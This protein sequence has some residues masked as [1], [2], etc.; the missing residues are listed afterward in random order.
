MALFRYRAVDDGGEQKLGTKAA[1]DQTHL[2]QKLKFEGYWL[3][4]AK[5]EKFK[6]KSLSKSKTSRREVI[7]LFIALSTMLNAGVPL[8][9]TLESMAEQAKNPTIKHAL[10]AITVSVNS[11]MTLSD[12]MAMHDDL[13]PKQVTTIVLAGETS[14]R[15]PET[16]AELRRYYEW[17]DQL[18]G[19]VKQA[20]TYPL[21][22]LAVVRVF[23]LVLFSFVVPQFTELLS[24]LDVDP[25]LVTVLVLSISDL[26]VATWWSMLATPF[27]IWFGLKLAIKKSPKFAQKFDKMK[28]DIPVFGPINRMIALSRFTHN[29]SMM[30]QSGIPI[31][32]CLRLC[33]ELVG[34][35]ELAA[36]IQEIEHKVGEGE[37][38]MSTLERHNAFSP[39]LLQMVRVG[40]STGQLDM[41][42]AQV[43]G[44]YDTEIP[45]QVKRVFSLMEP[46][47]MVGLIGVVG[48]VALAIFLPLI[49]LMGA[50]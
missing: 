7:D 24:G 20:S 16:F 13:F 18:V 45:R 34:N 27:V 36:I 32:D 33:G 12:A 28:L 35:A 19:E 10:S 8:L 43:S 23:I 21:V 44:Y 11:G 15:L 4:E 38:M 40:E 25:P 2:Y 49:S 47:V 41:A 42:M 5:E 14:G 3:L 9:E 48:T 6:Q 26:V 50:M 17:L 37:G 1:D 29:F 30:Y 46:I 39:M 31:L 22:V